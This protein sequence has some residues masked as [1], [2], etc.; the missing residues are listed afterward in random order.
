MPEFGGAPRGCGLDLV[1]GVVAPTFTLSIGRTLAAWKAG[2]IAVTALCLRHHWLTAFTE[3][4]VELADHLS[5]C[6]RNSVIA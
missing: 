4:A 2:R 3:K 1:E 6:E 5:P